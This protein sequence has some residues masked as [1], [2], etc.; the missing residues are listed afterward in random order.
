MYLERLLLRNFRCFKEVELFFC[1]ELN[2]IQGDNAQGKTSLLEAIVFLSTGRSFR[3]LNLKELI[4][5]GAPFFYLEASFYNQ[6]ISQS[7]KV[8]FDGVKRNLQINESRFTTFNPL[9]G[10]LPTI[11][12]APDHLSLITGPPAERRRF[13]DL[14]LAQTDPNYLY[15]IRRY[16]GA[17]QQRN[18]LLKQ[19][20]EIGI[21]SWE[22]IMAD[23]SLYILDKRRETLD[24]LQEPMKVALGELSL[25]Q[26]HLEM[27]YQAS[28]DIDTSLLSQFQSRRPKELLYGTSLIGP[29]RDDFIITLN[30]KSA[31]HYASEGQKRSLLA[32]LRLGQWQR[33]REI[34]SEPPLLSIDDF[35]A[36]LDSQRRLLL[37]KQMDNRGQVFVT[38]PQFDE[39]SFSLSQKSTFTISSGK[40]IS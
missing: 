9:L 21:N 33:V 5:H 13:L 26:D 12:Y 8:Y 27:H 32:S 23:S 14:H 4:Q 1:P 11:L 20:S 37:Q 34:I 2:F 28:F 30:G 7:V 31:R 40:I 36:H 3:T 19:K 16:T 18:A 35:G 25:N 15:H 39:R 17:M 24:G 29:H 10:I 38:A 22:E 6:G